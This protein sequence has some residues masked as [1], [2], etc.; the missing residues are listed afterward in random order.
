MLT[1]APAE[2]TLEELL[3]VLELLEELA[4]STADKAAKERTIV[5]NCIFVI[6]NV[7]YD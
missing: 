6:V 5:E 7:L 1:A 4:A 3:L 2:E